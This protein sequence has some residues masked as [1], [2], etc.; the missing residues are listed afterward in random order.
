MLCLLVAPFV[1]KLKI[2]LRIVKIAKGF[3]LVSI[4]LFVW[5]LVKHFE[6]HDLRKDAFPEDVATLIL[7]GLPEHA[8]Y[9]V[10]G[11]EELGLVAY[12]NL[13]KGIR[14][15]VNLYSQNGTLFGNRLYFAGSSPEKIKIQLSDFLN[16]GESIYAMELRP[17]F[18]KSLK[19]DWSILNKAG[20]EIIS[21][22]NQTTEESEIDLN[23][24]VQFMNRWNEGMY[25]ERWKK[26]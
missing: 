3:S 17:G 16:N 26:I 22:E 23:L 1:T 8:N 14:S 9:F 19:Q 2:V 20:Y 5:P 15:D 24:I 10:H 18:K 7:K 4:I 21:H 11:S 13:V 12:A 25:G 6:D